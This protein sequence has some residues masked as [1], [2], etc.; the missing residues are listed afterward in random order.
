M[1]YKLLQLLLGKWFFGMYFAIGL[2][3][4]ILF[5][6]AITGVSCTNSFFTTLSLMTGSDPYSFKDSI[7]KHKILWSL[8]WIIHI[9]SWLFIPALISL[10]VTNAADDIKK[11]GRLQRS[12]MELVI[13]A[14]V[15][16]EDAAE[17]VSQMEN[18]LKRMVN[19]SEKK[20]EMQ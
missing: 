11:A 18:E 15:R 19:E 6:L 5:P 16:S 20:G 1:K 7:E 13:E 2:I 10:I 14:G 4:F 17:L 9:A 3:Y 12:L 8:A